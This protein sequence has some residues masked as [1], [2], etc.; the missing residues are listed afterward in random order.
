MCVPPST[1][2]FQETSQAHTISSFLPTATTS[3]TPSGLV[4]ILLASGGTF[5]LPIAL[6]SA[7]L[8]VSRKWPDSDIP[9]NLEQ[10]K[11]IVNVVGAATTSLV[12][13]LNRWSLKRMLAVAEAEAGALARGIAT[14]TTALL[15]GQTRPLLKR[16]T[17]KD[18]AVGEENA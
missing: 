12:A 13:V 1:A 8:A 14:E 5:L 15:E 9:K 2:L 6:S 16:T 7:Q 4:G 10:I 17:S 18:R 11:V 3:T